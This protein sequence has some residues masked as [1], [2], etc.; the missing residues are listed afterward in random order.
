MLIF[1]RMGR[2]SEWSW[3]QE[4][5]LGI[6]PDKLNILFA[7][8]SVTAGEALELEDSYPHK[9][10]NE[11]QK[12]T[13]REVS[14]DNVAFPGAST[15]E[16]IDQ[17]FLYFEKHGHPDYLFVFLPDAGRDTLRLR[18]AGYVYLRQYRQLAA[19]CKVAGIELFVSTWAVNINEDG[20]FLTP[21][22]I[23]DKSK[24]PKRG[25]FGSMSKRNPDEPRPYW[26]QQ[27][28]HSD[29]YQII[30]SAI[31]SWIP[32]TKEDMIKRVYE[33]D[34]KSKHPNSLLA[35]D[36]VHAGISFHTFWYE[37]FID[38]VKKR[39]GKA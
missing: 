22:G 1:D 32:Y 24:I 35:T 29:G 37:M 6:V 26:T 31:D 16:T 2:L 19:Y 28:I 5:I 8:C 4:K 25:L 12:L 18:R 30:F 9:L 20:K 15:M 13:G 14:S 10:K 11:I 39:I 17:C 3:H 21:E 36:G 27:I 33:L 34:V 7:G 23:A 38:A